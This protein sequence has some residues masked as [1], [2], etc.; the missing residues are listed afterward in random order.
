V[1]D[2][3]IEPGQIVASSFSAPVLFTLAEDLSEMELQVDIDEA[4][5]AKVKTGDGATFTSRPIGKGSSR[6]RSPKS[7]TR[8][9][10]S[11]ASSLTRPS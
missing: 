4:D 9:K 7:A 5:M 3:A 8:R 1:L 2:R 10:P 6:P 11:R